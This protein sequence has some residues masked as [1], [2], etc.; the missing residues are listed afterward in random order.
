MGEEEVG[1]ETIGMRHYKKI[2]LLL[3]YHL[4]SKN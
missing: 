4:N 1:F 2:S 3:N